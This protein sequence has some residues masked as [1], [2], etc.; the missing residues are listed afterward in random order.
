MP[1][2]L[3]HL[4]NRLKWLTL[5]SKITMSMGNDHQELDNEYLAYIPLYS[6]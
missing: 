6:I 4:S 3:Q 5:V 1:V 2:S